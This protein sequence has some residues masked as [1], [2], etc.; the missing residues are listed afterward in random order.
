MRQGR[1][2]GP[3]AVFL[4]LTRHSLTVQ[5]VEVLRTR[6][7]KSTGP[8]AGWKCKLVTGP[9]CPLKVSYDAMG[10]FLWRMA[11][12]EV[13]PVREGQA[14]RE[15]QLDG[16]DSQRRPARSPRWQRDMYAP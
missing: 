12:G 7:P 11:V 16:S 6:F 2:S 14:P 1:P 5:S 4:T 3:F 15:A 10:P 13:R 8:P 9:P